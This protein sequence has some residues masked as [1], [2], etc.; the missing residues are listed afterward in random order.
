MENQEMEKQAKVKQEPEKQK[1]RVWP[2]VKRLIGDI[3]R[4]DSRQP[5]RVVIHTVCGGLYPFLAIL[6]PKL[7]IGILEQG[8]PDVMK[9]LLPALGVYF[10]AAALLGYMAKRMDSMIGVKNMRRRLIYIVELGDKLTGM[11][12]RYV[13][14][15]SFWEKNE[16]AMS[17][18]SNNSEGIEGVSNKICLLPA[19]LVSLVGMICMAAGL[20]PLL[21]LALVIH[22]AVTMW[23]SRQDHRYRYARREEEA[24]GQ[25]R[26]DYYYRTTH[27]FFFGKDIR[28]YNFRERIMANYQTE[29]DSLRD[30]IA[31]MARHQYLVGL[32]GIL[33]LLLTN[34]LMY[35]ILI[36]QTMNGLPISSFTMYVALINTL[37]ASM[38]I[39][40]ED[41][42]FIQNQCQYVGDFYRLVD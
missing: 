22:V 19:S 34:V 17:A 37:M 11:D 31:R 29:I 35:G 30:L 28:I 18:G 40:G 14:D 16:K 15:A 21:L 9:K 13:E 1:Y 41:V 6:L 38:L 27:D 4:G 32:T 36:G 2:V 23:I 26:I 10:L 3:R 24:R 25:R 5:G 20:S 7:A 39:F 8:G 33:T 12:Y 42:T